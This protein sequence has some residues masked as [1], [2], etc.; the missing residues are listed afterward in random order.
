MWP[1][2]ASP[3]AAGS[4]RQLCWQEAVQTPR[5]GT[6]P[7]PTAQ[8]GKLRH[9]PARWGWAAVGL[10]AWG[11]PWLLLVTAGGHMAMP[12]P[13]KRQYILGNED[14]VDHSNPQALWTH[15]EW[16]RATPAGVCQ[17]GGTHGDT[18]AALTSRVALSCSAAASLE[19]RQ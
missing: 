6:C 4:C 11:P 8:V 12:L 16:G 18:G 19:P 7:L 1:G 17:G 9:G 10:G 3:R 5:A 2:Q 15:V 14:P 13:G